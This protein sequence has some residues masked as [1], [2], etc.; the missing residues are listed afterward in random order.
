MV[1]R[2]TF[3]SRPLSAWCGCWGTSAEQISAGSHRWT[4][5]SWRDRYKRVHHLLIIQLQYSFPRN[6]SQLSLCFSLWSY[7]GR[8]SA[9]MKI[10]STSSDNM[11]RRWA[12]L[13]LTSSFFS[14]LEGFNFTE[15][16]LEIS[17]C[18]SLQLWQTNKVFKKYFHPLNVFTFSHVAIPL[19][20]LLL[21]FYLNQ[22]NVV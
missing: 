19:H 22:H 17:Y 12:R 18:Y 20:C 3:T 13:V 4:L 21:G 15:G 7:G 9:A 2:S 5:T 1:R 6:M 8:M 11:L 16:Q 10:F 14:S